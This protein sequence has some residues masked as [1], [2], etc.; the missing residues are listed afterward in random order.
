[1]YDKYYADARQL[2]YSGEA[3]YFAS[4]PQSN[5]SFK[6]LRDPPPK[7]TPYHTHGGIIALLEMLEGVINFVYAAWCQDHYASW[8]A[9]EWAWKT[10]MD[11]MLWT[12]SK[13]LSYV[14]S[15]DNVREKALIGLM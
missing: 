15:R 13:W 3:R 4:Y 11:F 8:A 5:S 9:R 7:G 6:A 1:M 12:K 14:G 2:K 10:N